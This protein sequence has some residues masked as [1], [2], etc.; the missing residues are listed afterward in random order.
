VRGRR[1]GQAAASRE[2]VEAAREAAMSGNMPVVAPVGVE[3]RENGDDGGRRKSILDRKTKKDADQDDRRKRENPD[4]V[5]GKKTLGQPI[6][7]IG[8]RT[9]GTGGAAPG[10]GDHG[11]R[12]RGRRGAEAS[13]AAR[14]GS[15]RL[16][17]CRRMGRGLVESM[18]IA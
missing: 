10:A 15:V 4:Q 5:I 8:G 9:L 14:V 11:D 12:P 6:H 13:A 1:L 2:V 3:A 17:P 18:F 7:G 16:I